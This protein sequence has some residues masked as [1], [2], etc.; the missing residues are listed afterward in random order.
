M[1]D[2][3]PSGKIALVTGAA[4]GVGRAVARR[5]A[6]AHD[7]VVQAGKD[8]L[9]KVAAELQKIGVDAYLS[10]C[11][12]LT[13]ERPDLPRDGGVCIVDVPASMQQCIPHSI[14]RTARRSTHM[15]YVPNIVR[16]VLYK[17]PT[18]WMQ[19]YKFRRAQAEI[20]RAHV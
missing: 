9:A 16:R 10:G 12:T 6:A 18:P 7:L 3:D 20:G 1:A 19:R 8:E 14:R 13:L 11:L 17:F 2:H 4:Q 5:L 15:V